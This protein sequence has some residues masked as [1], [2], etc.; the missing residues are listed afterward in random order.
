MEGSGSQTHLHVPHPERTFGRLARV[1]LSLP[2]EDEE[3]STTAGM[4]HSTL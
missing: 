2:N 1:F 4:T 3:G